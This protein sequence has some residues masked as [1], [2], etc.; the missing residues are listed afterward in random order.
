M[1]NYEALTPMVKKAARAAGSSFPKHYDP[2]DTEQAIWVWVL[3]K[4]N[5][6]GNIVRD[7]EQRDNEVLKPLYDMMLKVATTFLRGEDR[8]IYGYSEDDVFHYSTDLIKEILEVIFTHEDWQ[9]FASSYDA[10]PKQKVDPA[11]AGNN[12]ASYVDVSQAVGTLADRQYNALVWRYKY[13]YTLENVG[14]ELGMTKEGAR[15]LL[16]GAVRAV[17]RAL[18]SKDRSDLR[19]VSDGHLRPSTTAQAKAMS[20]SQ[21]EG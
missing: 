7:T 16:D 5:T 20:E 21:Y 19:N 6:V 12:L 2:A 10:M 3:E 9:S 14:S 18:G 13:H 8:A 4:R 1:L 15:Q 11:T 17:Q